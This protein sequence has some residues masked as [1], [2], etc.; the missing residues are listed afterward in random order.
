MLSHPDLF[1]NDA[2][3]NRSCYSRYVSLRNITANWTKAETGKSLNE[4]VRFTDANSTPATPM[5]PIGR[6]RSGDDTLAYL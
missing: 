1:A 4:G 2:K 6:Q 3:Y 5:H